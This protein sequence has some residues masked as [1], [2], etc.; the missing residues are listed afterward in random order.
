MTDT[1]TSPDDLPA[2]LAGPILRRLSP[3]RLRIWL[4]AS[5]PLSL[6]LEL[7]PSGESPRRQPLGEDDYRLVPLGRHAL[8]YLIDAPLDEPL[9]QDTRIDYDLKVT[10]E[11]ETSLGELAPHLCHEGHETPAFVLASSHR[12]LLHGS[13]RRPHYDGPDGLAHLDSWLAQRLDCPEQWPAWLLMTG[14]QIYADDVAGPLL[15]AI[16]AL[17]ERLGLFDE[18]LEG[19][20]ID[21]SQSLYAS[22]FSYYRREE[23]LPDVKSS[24]ALK[25]RFFGGVRK[26][27]FTSASAANH[28]MTFAEMVAMYLLVWS[29]TPWRLIECQPPALEE[30]RRETY[31]DQARIIDD[32]VATLPAAARVMAQLPSLMIFDDHDVTDDWNLTAQWESTAYGH[33]F[34]KR[35]IG[36]A[37]LAYLLCQGW[38][39][40]PERLKAPLDEAQAL[41]SDANDNQGW[42]DKDQQD[43]CLERLFR[44]EGW[45]FQVEGSPRL[46]VLDTRTRRWRNGR[47][48]ERPSGLMDWEA[49]SEFQQELIDA[50]SAVIVSPAPMFGV[51]LIETI[52]KLFTLAGKPLLVDAENW[53]AH[54]GAA[55]VMLNIFRHARTPGHYVILSGDVHYSFVY[56]VRIRHRHQ[57]PMIWQITS[58]GLK[59]CFPDTLLD[60][61]DRLNRWLYSPRSPLN[62]FTQ[63]RPMA[64]EPRDPDRAKAGERLWNG[65]GIGLVTLA[66]DGSPEDIRQLDARGM[67]V[68]FPPPEKA[69]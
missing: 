62:W 53:M 66:E 63:R 7:S 16:H 24:A 32:F 44:F 34:S 65:P 69:P 11:R 31:D 54:R 36:N 13:C 29:P 5:R 67:E 64:V 50:P 39:N 12:R 57:G 48:P 30:E 6:T 3:E 23:L 46:V 20:T 43:A 8:L 25:D 45:E 4:V 1:G 21:D 35:I 49:L 52:Q 19:S 61:F 15:V 14:D 47:K 17:I 42:L 37:L 28:L 60:T 56:D 26:P 55:S 9:P 10:D 68:V 38:G 51:K 18:T 40:A 27:V 41:L 33:P 59:N 58:S 2:I 22:P